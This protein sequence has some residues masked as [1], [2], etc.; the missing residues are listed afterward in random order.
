MLA[1]VEGPTLLQR[2]NIEK[3]RNL[4]TDLQLVD[5]ARGIISLF[6]ARQPAE[7]GGIPS[8][9]FPEELPDGPAYQKLV[10]NLMG[11]ELIRGKLLSE[12]GT[13]A[14]VVLSLK[15]EVVESGELSKVVADIREAMNDDLKDS[16]LKARLSGVPVMQLEIRNALERDRLIYNAL[17]F[18]GGC[19]IAIL[20]FRRFSLMIVAAAPPLLA[21]LFAVGL[22]GWLGFHLNMFLNVMTPLIMVISFSDS[23]Q[24]TFAARDRMMAGEDRRTAFANAIHVVGPACVLTHATTGL[25]FLGLMF[26]DSDL[27]RTFGQ[28]G[29]ISMIVALVTVLS[30]VPVLGILLIRN[31]AVFAANI[32]GA[33]TGVDALRRF[34][35]WVAANMVSRPGVIL[36]LALILV[37]GLGAIYFGLEPRYR[38]ADQV[39]DR[40]QAVA[41]SAQLDAK[42]TGAN[43]I[44]VLI[45]F[46]KGAGLYAPQTLDV[47]AKVH[48][49]LEGQTGVGNVWSVETL[50]R[51]LSQKLGKSDADTLKQYVDLLPRFL[52]RRFVSADQNS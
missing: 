27:I 16:D 37:G 48:A 19:A 14:L 7:D 42:L 15:P 45:K 31:D 29:F 40:E 12:D 43:P 49:A 24:L 25:S 46:P 33:D 47:I 13:L 5:G 17:G 11:N 6:S 9:V 39:P 50:H 36:L 38:L 44:D 41:A 51:W 20:F 26:S 2:D 18:L 34:C 4:V 23:M 32:K 30:M 8:P 3:L 10:D 21:I 1:V 52:V 35:G 22:L 28:A